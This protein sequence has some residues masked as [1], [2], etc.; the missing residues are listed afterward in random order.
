L[1]DIRT[2][3]GASVGGFFMPTTAQ[4]FQNR[5]S[6][7]HPANMKY[8]QRYDLQRHRTKADGTAL[9]YIQVTIEGKRIRVAT[10]LHW[11]VKH[12]EQK[13]LPRHR[14]DTLHEDYSRQLSRIEGEIN[15][16]FIWARLS[17]IELTPKLFEAEL[18]N[19][20][21]RSDFIQFFQRS[22]NERKIKGGIKPAT[23]KN[24]MNAYASLTRFVQKLP[25]NEI[26]IDWL[27][28]YK[29]WLI[30]KEGLKLS[31]VETKLRVLRTYMNLAKTQGIHF[32]YPFDGFRMPKVG[33]T[34][35]FLSESEFQ[36]ILK[37]YNSKHYPE[38]YETP[39]K[40]FLFSCYTGLRISDM[41]K[42]R[43]S[44]IEGDKLVWSME[45]KRIDA[46]KNMIIPIH[47]FALELTNEGR[48][49]LL[50]M[51]SEQK[52]NANLK[53]ISYELKIN[54]EIS[55]HWARHTF[56]TRFLRHGGR[57]E[58]LQ[59]LLGHDSIITTMKYVHVDNQDM[60]Q[61]LILT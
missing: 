38:N 53:K 5:T 55:M 25:F 23:F 8:S 52:I 50:P 47:P 19:K 58:V 54:K 43:R 16:V 28:Q 9:I 27:E 60:K 49:Q 33:E 36:L 48:G 22:L 31:S 41:K 2:A 39:L 21:S 40:L 20:Y 17:N 26:S 1:T 10:D 56:A 3:Y 12:F 4:H 15:E 45:K 6:T 32:K 37:L 24:Q 44:N 57:I 42:L 7:Q 30:N 35:R 14:N 29:F 11:S 34:L 46:A 13:I 51:I 61:I 59:Q 18:K